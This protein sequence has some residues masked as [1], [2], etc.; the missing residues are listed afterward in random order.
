MRTAACIPALIAVLC[1]A[2]CTPRRPPAPD[3]SLIS[4]GAGQRAWYG[5][6]AEMRAELQSLIAQIPETGGESRVLLARKIVGFGEPAV[7]Q[8]VCALKDSSSEIRGAAAW[9]LGFLGDPRAADVLLGALA[10]PVPAVRYEAAASLLK[11]KDDRGLATIVDGLEDPDAMVRAKCII[12][13]KELTGESFGYEADLAPD[14]RKAAVA[15]W[16]AWVDDRRARRE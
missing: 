14:D 6:T 4:A 1:V 7:P 9:M 10:D 11:M 5:G 8:L 16:R 2:A 13:L 12:L 3:P 15:R